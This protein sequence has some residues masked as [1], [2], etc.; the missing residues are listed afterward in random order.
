MIKHKTEKAKPSGKEDG[1]NNPV[2]LKK[3]SKDQKTHS[4]DEGKHEVE[5]IRAVIKQ[6]GKQ[7]VHKK[8]V[9]H[10][11]TSHIPH[12][13]MP[14]F[15]LDEVDKILQEKQIDKKAIE[16]SR[17]K[18]IKQKIAVV[19]NGPV[20]AQKWSSASLQDILGFDPKSDPKAIDRNPFTEK[21]I[22][23]KYREYYTLLTDLKSHVEEGLMLHTHETLKET[24]TDLAKL[25]M[26]S[27]SENFDKDMMLGMVS[28]EKEILDEINAAIDRIFRGTYGV[29]EI[30]HGEIP[31]ERLK[32]VPFTRYSKEGQIQIEQEKRVKA[33]QQE[34]RGLF[35]DDEESGEGKAVVDNEGSYKEEDEF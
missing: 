33:K 1:K 16:V 24:S 35:S 30:T 29:C 20:V 31:K 32:A 28:S 17:A 3:E 18:E 34:Y 15:T 22:P 12:K 27:G 23:E 13:E 5:M 6:S 4:N 10:K 25:T 8:L 21:K 11:M 7:L 26:D 19:E 14:V 2:H 9:P